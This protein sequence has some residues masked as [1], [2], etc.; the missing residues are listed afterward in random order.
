MKV[1]L[2]P[3]VAKAVVLYHYPCPDGVF[4]ALAAHLYHSAVGCP[5]HFLPN[6]VFQPLTV[7]DLNV[8]G[9]DV[10]YLLDFAG[11]Q[12]F[13]VDL[14]H[15]AKQVIVLDHHKTALETLP[16]NGEG[17]QNLLS[18]LDMSR[19]GATV[20][21]DYFQEK[22]Q[23]ADLKK[24]PPSLIYSRNPV[25]QSVN[26]LS[27]SKLQR[28]RAL[29]KYIEDADLWKWKLPDSKAFSSGLS[30]IGLE[31][32]YLKNPGIFEQLLELD[33]QDLICRGRESLKSKQAVID[34][35]LVES[36]RPIG[37][38]IYVQPGYEGTE[39]QFK[40]SLRSIGE[41]ADTTKISQAYGGGGHRN[42][43]SFLISREE[44]ERWKS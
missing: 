17:P 27:E 37:A 7:K 42:A 34:G 18:V 39:T 33:T 24:L 8:E 9:V 19:S 21:Y 5:V 3:G 44:L 28:V 15:K 11:P 6:S 25:S 22:L 32:S 35:V 23:T 10:F 13:A 14:A 16:R 41:S 2:D 30:D 29:F 36:F 31:F 20:A 4:A 38:V 1:A 26:L 40:V 43:S 12:S